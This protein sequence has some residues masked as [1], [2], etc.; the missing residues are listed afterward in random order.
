MRRFLPILVLLLAVEGHA[1]T[2]KNVLILFD[3][4]KD[5]PPNIIASQQIRKVLGSAPDFDVQIFEE[6]L[7][8]TRLNGKGSPAAT[9]VFFRE[10]YAGMQ[11][12]V[13]IVVGPSALKFG[14]QYGRGLF[15]NVPIVFL[16][17]EA[18]EHGPLPRNVTGVQYHWDWT[19]TLNLAL[20]LHPAA[21]HVFFVSGTAD[22]D[23]VVHAEA[24]RELQTFEPNFDFKDLTD[25]SLGDLLGQVAHLPE[26]S[27]VLYLTLSAWE[28]V[29]ALHEAVA[30]RCYISPFVAEG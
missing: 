26:H 2:T 4:W 3:D 15:P 14:L 19:G 27:I 1:R 8:E 13:L 28:L 11:P 23:R 24:R 20:R 10:K 7:D 5:V 25:L 16:N 18:E 30:G 12:D 6:Y 9:A 22:Y 21:K 29:T 17:V